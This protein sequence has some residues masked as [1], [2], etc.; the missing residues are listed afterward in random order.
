MYYPRFKIISDKSELDNA[1]KQLKLPRKYILYVGTIYP[2]KN[3][4]TDIKV[5]HRLI[6]E[7]NNQLKLVIVGRRGWGYEEVEKTINT[8]NLQN[9]IIFYGHQFDLLPHI[10]SLAELLL[11]PSYYEAFPAPPLEAMAC[12][13][14]VIASTEGGLPEV[15]GDAG[16]MRAPDDVVGLAACCTQVLED[17]TKRNNLIEKGH[18]QIKKFFWERCAEETISIYNQF[19]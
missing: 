6:N 13:T 4:S 10:Y 11:F 19:A 1:R 3:I 15:I 7:Y 9:N 12:G 14:P 18:E 8:L 2:V 16:M 5:F 17:K